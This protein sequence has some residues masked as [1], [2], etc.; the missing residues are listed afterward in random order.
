MF[1]IVSKN[2]KFKKLA[3]VKGGDQN[4]KY[5]VLKPHKYKIDDLPQRFIKTLN[6]QQIDE[7]SE[8]IDTQFEP[9]DDFMKEIYY[10][11]LK[12][13]EKIKHKGIRLSSGK[14]EPLLDHTRYERFYVAGASGSGKTYYSTK[15]VEQYLKK[16]KR[17]DN[18]FVMVS[19]VAP[20]EKLE[21]MFPNV[22]D[23]ADVYN[24]GL[25]ADAIHDSIILFD[26]V[27]SI[28]DR[29]VKNAVLSSINHLVETNR[30]SH[31]TVIVINHLLSSAHETRKLLNEA[32]TI[33]FFPKASA[34]HSIVNYLKAYEHMSADMIRRI[35]NLP[36]RA[37]SL[38]K[39]IDNPYIL[40]ER[41]AF[42]L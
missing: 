29:R 31:T 7:L 3:K 6:P 11:S 40:F 30:H 25:P 32:T 16:H 36:T 10:D 8:A 17:E 33:V 42:L 2:T 28:P 5:L 13:F 4:G 20:S 35:V 37:V 18:D 21:E 22:I 24:E 27:L 38:Y 34:K 41:G 9:M 23:P 15:L 14:F 12:E 19:G 1:A 39:G 26:D